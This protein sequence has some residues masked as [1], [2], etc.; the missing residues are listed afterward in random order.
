MVEICHLNALS[1]KTVANNGLPYSIL[2]FIP[3]FFRF[4]I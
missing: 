1:L 2:A 3:I 4:I